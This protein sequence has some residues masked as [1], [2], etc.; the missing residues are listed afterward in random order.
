M[1]RNSDREH[2]VI[3]VLVT[4][5]THGK[6]QPTVWWVY[7]LTRHEKPSARKQLAQ[8]H[9]ADHQQKSK[10]N[11]GLQSVN[12]VPHSVNDT[13]PGNKK[14]LWMCNCNN[15]FPLNQFI[16][17]NHSVQ[18]PWHT[19]K[20]IYLKQQDVPKEKYSRE[21]WFPRTNCYTGLTQKQ[22]KMCWN[23]GAL[24]KNPAFNCKAQLKSRKIVF[25]PYWNSHTLPLKFMLCMYKL[26]LVNVYY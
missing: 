25:L 4:V 18:S 17:R 15:S 12:S 2:G 24:C 16:L 1:F 6:R 22:T 10:E 26:N 7:N 13:V 8:G 21:V 19:Q 23:L 20:F 9:T 5:Q 14:V 11:T 3:T